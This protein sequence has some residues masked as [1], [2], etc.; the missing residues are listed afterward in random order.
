MWQ[1]GNDTTQPEQAQMTDVVFRI[2]CPRLQVDHAAAL[3]D[4]VC[5]HAPQI[6]Q[7]DGAGIHPIHVA[8]SQNGWERPEDGEEF[9]LLSKRTRFKIRAPIDH[10][11]T[12]ISLLTGVTLDVAG[13]TLHILSGQTRA[14]VPS[15]TL[16]SRYTYFDQTEF[17]GDE[18]DFIGHIISQCKAHDF[19]PTKILC[20]KEHTINTR[21]GPV[22]T[23]SVLLADVP[24]AQ[25]LVL[26]DNGIGNGRTI[27]CGLLIPHK[28]TGAVNDGGTM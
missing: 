15:S 20:G 16:L 24:A 11:A 8:G 3:A 2:E 21:N 28:D 25:S 19:S 22:L 14:L 1:E 26:Q 10:A 7:M 12:L 9:L 13:S 4:A 6:V 17:I 23:R 27:G 5:E 18:S